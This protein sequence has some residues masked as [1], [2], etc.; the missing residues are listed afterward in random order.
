MA[1]AQSSD[2]DQDL[3]EQLKAGE[4]AAFEALLARYQGM[5]YQLPLSVR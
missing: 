1:A 5:V 3:V 2:L 4:E